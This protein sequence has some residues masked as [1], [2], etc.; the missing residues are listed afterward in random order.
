MFLG[1]IDIDSKELT[2]FTGNSLNI[3]PTLMHV[4]GASYIS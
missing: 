2:H 3:E 1:L 4:V